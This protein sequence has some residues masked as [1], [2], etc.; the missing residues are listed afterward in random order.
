MV[1][2]RSEGVIAGGGIA[3]LAAALAFRK[4]GYKVTV[5]EQAAAFAPV[6]AGILLQANGLIVL[7]VLG[8]GDQVRALG[9]AMPRCKLRD[10]RGRCLVATEL[11]A[12]LPLQ[13][14]PVCIHRAPLHNILWQA[15]FSAGFP[16]HFSCRVKNVTA[17]QA[18]T[19]MASDTPA[20]V[21]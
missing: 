15:C 6:G 3:G 18:V 8:L 4:A 7:D 21:V 12:H 2:E 5:L 9:T 14:W 16:I 13:Y 10:S 17:N 19:A 20:G 11:H 1:S